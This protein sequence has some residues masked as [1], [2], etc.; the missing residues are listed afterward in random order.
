MNKR[1]FDKKDFVT[2][3]EVLEVTGS[4]LSDDQK[5]VNL[6]QKIFNVATL[7]NGGVGEISFLNAASYIKNFLTSQVSFCFL[8]AKY[9]PKMPQTMIGLVHK[10]PYFAYAQLLS[11]LFSYKKSPQ[12]S[13]KSS[14]DLSLR[15]VISDSA[16]IG[17][18]T[19]I[20]PGAYIGNNVII[21][22]GCYI[23][24]NSVIEDNCII[25]NNCT[26][27]S[28]VTI[29]YAVIGNN[30]V[31]HNGAQIGQDGFGFVHEQGFNHKI[32]QLGIVEIGNDAE[33]G[34]A[35]CID[36]GAI[37]NTKIGNNV[38]ID[39]LCQIAHNVV[40]DDGSLIAGCSGI[41]GSAKIGKF[42]Q[43]GGNS[44]IAG[45]LTIGDG[46]K[47]AGMSGIAK[48]VGPMQVVAGIP[49]V[50]IRDWHRINVKLSQIIKKDL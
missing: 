14:S 42:V 19:K 33:I 12:I 48:N 21:G 28:L 24:A 2:L 7:D 22:D 38:K 15:A 47:I 11:C 20:M 4:S 36:R 8:E 32:M 46:A 25:G 27:K 23:G 37:E 35:T 41:A 18:E 31:I 39:N 3:K 13:C 1:F 44:S 34:A 5:N 10:N 50:P 17:K 43:I 29:S 9:L 26:I 16:L 49:A 30:V 6:E 45:H 40:I